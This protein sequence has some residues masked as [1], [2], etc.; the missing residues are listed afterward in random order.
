MGY[1]T[2]DHLDGIEPYFGQRKKDNLA[3][4]PKP[5]ATCWEPYPNGRNVRDH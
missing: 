3:W 2:L 1:R 5:L 4:L